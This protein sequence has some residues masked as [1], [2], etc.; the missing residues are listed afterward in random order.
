MDNEYR[1]VDSN[2][3]FAGQIIKMY[4]DHIEMPDGTV[5]EREYVR[6]PGAV[7]IVPM[8]TDGS[9]LLVLQY[10]HPLGKEIWEIPAGKLDVGENPYDCAKRE[11][12]EET[13]LSGELEELAHFYTTPGYSD[14]EFHLFL[15][16]GLSDTKRLPPDDEIIAFKNINA[17]DVLAMIRNGEIEDAKSICGLC[18]AL[19]TSGQ[20]HRAKH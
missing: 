8:L 20:N 4:L 12:E 16:S 1:L 2:L 19:L 6:H 13:G 10:R 15:A 18:L 11:L 14:E 7:G 17:A 9:F 3:E 5:H